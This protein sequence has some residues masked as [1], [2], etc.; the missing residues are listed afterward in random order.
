MPEKVKEPK[1]VQLEWEVRKSEA[2]SVPE[3]EQPQ[4]AARMGAAPFSQIVSRYK[5]RQRDTLVDTVSTSLSYSGE[6]AVDLG[7][8]E[9]TGVLTELTDT[10]GTALPFAVIAVTEQAKVILGKKSQKAALKNT[11]YRMVKTGAAMGAGALAGAVGG[12]AAAIPAAVGTRVIMD[13]YKSKA[14]LNS[15]VSGRI[16]RLKELRQN[17]ENQSDTMVEPVELAEEYLET[18]EE[19]E[20]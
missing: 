19:Y 2:L 17:R 6:V 15:R 9:D 20:P 11:F 3:E 16:K 14:L 13:H 7:L 5:K 8:M 10:I 1:T 4:Q 12:V 18:G